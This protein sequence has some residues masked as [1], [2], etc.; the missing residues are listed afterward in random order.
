VTWTDGL[1]CTGSFK[2]EERGYMVFEDDS[3]NEFVC[4]PGH[5][6]VEKLEEKENG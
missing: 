6:K 4:F 3:G 2:R 1:V 5:A